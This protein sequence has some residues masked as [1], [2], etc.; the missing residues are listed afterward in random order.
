MPLPQPN[1]RLR[2]SAQT[3]QA[4]QAPNPV[5]NPFAALLGKP[6]SAGTLSTEQ[7]AIVERVNSYLSGVQTLTGN[8]IQVGP[9][10]SRTQGDFFISKPGP[11]PLRI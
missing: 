8:F 4:T 11:R 7:R 1:L 10:G 6:G 3:A 2:A 5:A 9:D